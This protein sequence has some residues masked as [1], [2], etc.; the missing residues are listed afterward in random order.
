MDPQ[1]LTNAAAGY[2]AM[3][4]QGLVSIPTLSI[5]TDVNLLFGPAQG[6]YVRRED[7]NQQQVNVEYILP[8][9][10]PGF[11]QE[12]GLEIQGQT[13][14]TDSGGDWKSKK[15]S[16]RLIFKGEFGPTK[17]HYKLFP[18][19]P[20]EEFDT[21]IVSAGH[22]LYWNYMPNDDQRTRA[23]YVRDQFVADLQNAM[24]GLSH[25]GR[26]VHLYLNGLY[27]GLHEMHERPDDSFAASY[28]GGDKKD[29]DVIKHDA[30]QVVSGSSST[31]N[32]L[33]SIARSGLTNN[34]TYENLQQY[35][36]VPN[37]IDYMLANFWTGNTDWAHK[38]YYASHRR[39]PAGL[40][41]YHAW[42]SEHTLK[43]ASENVV[44]KSDSG[45]PTEL[46]QL[47]RNNAEFRLLFADHV[48][49]HFFNGG[50]FYTDTNNP[51]YNPAFP[52]RNRPAALYMKRI[53]EIDPA[54]V[55]ESA[56]WGDVGSTRLN[57]PCTRNVTWLN[58]LDALMGVRNTAG[59]TWNFFPTR[60]ATVLGQFR[61]L[62]V[63]PTNLPPAFSQ[64][65]GNVAA[66][67]LLYMT[68][69]TSGATIYYTTN[70]ADPRV[71]GSGAVSPF[72]L[73]YTGAPVGLNQ[74]TVV[75]ARTLH[76]SAWSALNEA[77]FTLGALGVPLR[78]TEI[79]YN[80]PGGDAHEFIEL[81]NG[82]ATELDLSG[83]T[84]EGITFVFQPGFRLAVGA[85]IVLASGVNPAS[86]A[87]NYPGVAPSGYFG[88]SLAN[89]G[90][91]LA[92]KDPSGQTIL[93]V[94]YDDEDG[95]PTAADGAGYTLEIIDPGGDPDAPANWRRSAALKGT[96]GQPP[97][98]PPAPSLV[99]NE[100]MAENLTAVDNG[101]TF[102]DWVELYNQGGVA[103]DL[104][105]WSL[106]DDGNPRK[107]VFTSGP[108]LQ[109]GDYLVVWCDDETNTTPGLHAGFALGRNG[110]SVFLYD[111]S[112][113]RIDAISFGLQ[114]ADYSLG[115]VAGAWQLTQPTPGVANLAAA[116]DTQSNLAIN[117][118][119]AN[120]PPGDDDWIE[121][122]N[123]SASAPVSLHD[124]YLGT[125]NAL[126]QLRAHSFIAPG[127][128]VQLQADQNRGPDH[129]D[130]RLP[131][132]GGVIVLY[133]SAG[134]EVNRVTYGPQLEGVSQGRLPDGSN[135]SVSFAGTASPG[136]TNYVLTYAGPRLNEVLAI[137][138]TA[139]TNGHGRTPDF[140]ELVNTDG[141]AFDLSG[142][143]LST[144]AG[145]ADQ[146]V[147]PP[148]TM[149]PGN[150]F[151]VVWFDEEQPASIVSGPVLDTGRALDG[152]SGAVY[153]HNAA[154][155][156]VDSVAYGFQVADMSIGLSSGQWSL[157]AN[158]SP[159]AANSAPAALGSAAGLRINEWM[160]APASGG[161]W[162]ELF[163]TANQPVSLSGLYLTDD[164]SIAGQTQFQ[165]AAL[166]FIGA[167]GFVKCE[168]DGDPSQ[169][170]NHVSFSLDAQGEMLRLYSSSLELIDSVEFGLQP[171]GKSQGRLPDGTDAIVSFPLTSTPGSANYLPAGA[172]VINEVLTHPSG[173]LEDAIELFNPSPAPVNIG[174]WFVSD[175]QQNFKK[176]RL[177]AGTFV[178]GNGFLVLYQNQFNGP[179]A[180]V[181]FT[182]NSARGGEVWLS[183]ADGVGNLTGYRAGAAFGAAESGV[184]IGRYETSG[185]ADFTALNQRTFGEDN[186]ATVEQ[187][188]TGTGLVNAAPRIGPLVIS[189]I[190]YHPPDLGGTNDDLLNEFIEI[191]NVSGGPVQ[192]FDPAFP[193]HRWRLQEGV[194][195]T[196]VSDVTLA[197]GACLL[198]VNFDPDGNAG[199][200]AAFRSRYSVSNSV[201]VYGPYA[202]K[203]DNGGEAISLAKPDQPLPDGFVPYVTVDRV[204]YS[205]GGPWPA[206][207][208]G[209][210]NGV[211][212]SL[213]RRNTLAY[214]N[215]PLNWL[216]GAPTAGHLGTSSLLPLPTITQQPQSQMTSAGANVTVSVTASGGAP[217]SY[218]WRRNGTVIPDATNAALMLLSVQSVD[219]GSYT[220]FVSNP[221]GSALS[222]PAVL[223]VGAVPS[224]TQQPQSQ[225][226]SAGGTAVFSVLATGGNLSY[227]WRFNGGDL[228]GQT[229]ATLT[230]NNVQPANAGAYVARISNT[231]GFTFSDPA[232]L[233][234]QPP[235]ITQHPQSQTN[236][237][238]FSAELSVQ[239]TG[240]A[241]LSY[242][243]RKN[244][245]NLPGATNAT[246]TLP[247]LQPSDS[248]GY[249]AVVYNLAGAATSSVA[250]LTVV[251]PV[252]I[253][254][255][256]RSTNVLAGN[257]VT[258]TVSAT[259]TGTLRYQWLFNDTTEIAGATG[260]NLTLSNLQLPQ[261]GLYSV[262]VSDDVSSV[263]SSNASVI[264]LVRPTITRQPTNAMTVAGGNAT[265]YIEAAGTVPIAFRWRKG[266]VTFTQGIIV[267]TPT[268]STLT[269]T[270]AR[271]SDDGSVFSVAVTNLAGASSPSSNAV[272]RVVQPPILSEPQRLSD[273]SFQFLIAT[274]TNL[275]LSIELSTNLM[276][277]TTLGTLFYTNGRVPFV[278]PAAANSLQRFYRA[279]V[280]P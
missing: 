236:Y 179:G 107:F 162:F 254:Q 73:T 226:A 63:Y 121:L 270:N 89:G 181:P 194:S 164:P 50:I 8:D 45:G 208:D 20:V 195:F 18:D 225:F 57:N 232:Y 223:T 240:D 171:E 193:G 98:M 67:F 100:L 251:I 49:K 244:G 245:A 207:A 276:N 29:Y 13:S 213:Q 21:L 165:L 249:S 184:S 198:V 52:E 153:L 77:T 82:G 264:V 150:G 167:F 35:L 152:Q 36:D 80:P 237:A 214:G 3:A 126:F 56:R 204:V 1:V 275:N 176:Y 268:S 30:G 53:S 69:L 253:L 78:V 156:V 186:P 25:H 205:D 84:F 219:E 9:G 256:P 4:R 133:D 250:T 62:R 187:F 124:I 217:L 248:G 220:V 216:A 23:Q 141:A 93:S 90:E 218:Q 54:I 148:G 189:E 112:T 269:V 247:N 261:T 155:Q 37:F 172:L 120:P 267:S 170:R 114:L 111:A 104:T 109:P 140:V 43:S 48:H 61:S 274:S 129:L 119:L 263:T 182:L 131:A 7:F 200:L 196:F 238:G 108:I 96:P 197:P 65:G 88:G 212:A 271:L 34:A 231:F 183:A 136:A 262:R 138:R 228:P 38:N 22:N 27:W 110:E 147:F 241:P 203:L 246:L 28:Y 146:W 94:D 272:L 166:S 224:V 260:A 230:L 255:H 117:E 273:G 76:N 12:C 75:K 70:G 168:A 279:R 173:P 47:L 55:C 51:I 102:P 192:L 26:F 169:G 235:S 239:A 6:V 149:I 97:T 66:G 95:W 143:R 10:S 123:R 242:Q 116:L 105:G 185:G 280:R 137:N 277:W 257:S 2:A 210:T 118:W 60:S 258:L 160:A 252:Q 99:L 229:S 46:F 31:L 211:G 265:F 243:W 71:Y 180:T 83:Y 233:V 81:M 135:N 174:G 134:V 86:F 17:L 234:M 222:E 278:D 127:G 42:D 199:Q 16:L 40:W 68:N 128:F 39:Q 44:T 5:V 142:M 59:N 103:V 259:G 19:S 139:V 41:R 91:R 202:G 175:S 215:E 227:Q 201:P 32:T 24:G 79:M 115:R 221:A 163:N 178:P 158:P 106:S 144:D 154:G 191:C 101:G 122:F 11:Q 177:P 14:P 72:A 92:I 159:G 188:R 145:Q 58:E 87:S 161:D 132:S 15:L 125:S 113:N 206:G 33:F 266:G 85:R 64:Q 157:L 151:L 209:T 130:F 74:T 190:M